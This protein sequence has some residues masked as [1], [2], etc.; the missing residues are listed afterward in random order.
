MRQRRSGEDVGRPGVG[1]AGDKH[2][3]GL[4]RDLIKLRDELPQHPKVFPQLLGVAWL[5]DTAEEVSTQHEHAG[6]HRVVSGKQL[7]QPVHHVDLV[8]PHVG[9]EHEHGV[10][11]VG[12]H[13]GQGFTLL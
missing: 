13:L 4:R 1:R 9:E 7:P 2:E 6:R 12:L 5:P 3:G 8:Q 11:V 10:R